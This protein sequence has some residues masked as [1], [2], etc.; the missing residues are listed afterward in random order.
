M[1]RDDFVE[2]GYIAKA[3][4]LK[5]EV[6]AVFDV[7]DLAEY[8]EEERFFLAKPDQIPQEYFLQSMNIQNEKQAIIRF[9]G[10][11]FRDEAEA[12]QGSTILFPKT[13]LP[14]LPDGRFYYY[15]ITGYLVVD[16]THGELGPV[17]GVFDGSA[18]DIL[19]FEYQGKEILVPMTE[20]FVLRAD[21]EK[22]H[23]LTALPEGL[24]ETYLEG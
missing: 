16:Q 12:L 18:Q 5:G 10:I 2:L 23:M 9:K 22:Q 19:A 4:G 20:A 14:E 11:R 7:Y 1:K 21:H 15:Q 3:H 6:K 17:M 24:L 8:L 13:E